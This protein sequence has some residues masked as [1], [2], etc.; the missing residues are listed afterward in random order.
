MKEGAIDSERA[1]I[2]HH[3]AAEDAE[4]CIGAFYNPT[5]LMLPQCSAILRAALT[6][7]V[8][9][10]N[11]L[12]CVSIL[13]EGT[14]SQSADSHEFLRADQMIQ[15]APLLSLLSEILPQGR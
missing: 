9:V 3:Q 14:L 13:E 2:K 5:V 11:L 6:A 4:P 8:R 12:H 1:V 15:R 10:A 7:P